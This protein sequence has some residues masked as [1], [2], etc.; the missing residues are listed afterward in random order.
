MAFC[1]NCG[2]QIADNVTFCTNCG[3]SM[4]T[5][6][7]NNGMPQPAQQMQQ[8]MQQSMQQPMQQ[9]YR[10]APK[11]PSNFMPDRTA[12]FDPAD[13]KKTK[14]LNIF[15]YIGM[16]F[17]LP[18][19]LCKGSKYT[20]FHVN[21]GLLVFLLSSICHGFVSVLATL[22]GWVVSAG[23]YS[24]YTPSRIILLVFTILL[25]SVVGA[26]MTLGIINVA[27]GKA[28]ELPL[29]GKLHIVD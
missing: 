8:P 2:V 4:N 20:K 19:I 9:A 18:A 22:F 23:A 24:L 10:P 13:I 6:P 27:T 3:A 21:Q 7:T 26:Y 25:F 16:L 29:I 11:Q 28:K 1:K 12:N 15:S 5:V 17:V 14:G